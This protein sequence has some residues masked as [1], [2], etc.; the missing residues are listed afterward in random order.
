MP[1]VYDPADGRGRRRRKRKTTGHSGVAT[2]HLARAVRA[3]SGSGQALTQPSPRYHFSTPPCSAPAKTILKKKPKLQPIATATVL[4][5]DPFAFNEHTPDL[6]RA[7]Q[8]KEP[9]SPEPNRHNKYDTATTTMTT[10][11]KTAAAANTEGKHNRQHHVIP[12]SVSTAGGLVRYAVAVDTRFLDTSE[13]RSEYDVFAQGVK[14]FL[15]TCSSRGIKPSMMAWVGYDSSP[16]SGAAS[17]GMI[18]MVCSKILSDGSLET[19]ISNALSGISIHDDPES[20]S[21]TTGFLNNVP[22]KLTATASWR[23]LAELGEFLEIEKIAFP[24]V[25]KDSLISNPAH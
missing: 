7:T 20:K 24:L 17:D 6:K 23:F 11:M 22:E 5:N 10:P 4:H 25:L 1:E 8:E 13:G 19:T 18:T 14:N 16:T 12:G 9:T 15:R 3:V 2:G 21:H